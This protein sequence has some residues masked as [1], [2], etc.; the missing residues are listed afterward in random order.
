MK[1]RSHPLERLLDSYER[2]KDGKQVDPKRQALF[3]H[4]QKCARDECGYHMCN[5]ARTIQRLY[6]VHK[7]L[8]SQKY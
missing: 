5:E 2:Y 4:A 3:E 6:K 8:P 7:E 1:N